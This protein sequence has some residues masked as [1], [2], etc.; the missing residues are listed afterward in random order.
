MS[1]TPQ[2]LN[3]EKYQ[4]NKKKITIIA[5]LVLIIG[6]LIGGGLITTGL[7]K[8]NQAKLSPEE[9]NQVQEEIDNYNV[10]LASLKAKQNQEI[11]DNGLS[12]SYYNLG[13]QI[14]KI[15]DEIKVLKEK[16]DPDTFY[17]VVFYGCGGFAIFF[18][19][20]IFNS[21]YTTAKGRE[22]S[23]FYAQQHIP[24]TREGIDEMAPTI[25]NV[26]GEITKGIK[27]ELKDEE[28]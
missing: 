27:K 19:F 3:E 26:A 15:Q 8:N 7:I 21:I 2:Y 17:L 24:V 28:K 13:N 23:A 9:I 16:L 1:K 18:T 22:I 4:A 14:D 6:L 10:Q 20:I 11:K 25:G 5:F 12:E